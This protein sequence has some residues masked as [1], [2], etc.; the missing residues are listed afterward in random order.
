MSEL[1][2]EDFV[3]GV[4][5][6]AG[7]AVVAG[8]DGSGLAERKFAVAM[9]RSKRKKKAEAAVDKNFRDDYAPPTT[10]RI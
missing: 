6:G 9:E 3:A 7:H 2:G 8:G 10:G 5:G 4:A 1:C